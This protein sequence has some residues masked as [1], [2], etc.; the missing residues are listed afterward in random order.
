VK[1]QGIRIMDVKLTG[2]MSQKHVSIQVCPV[3]TSGVIPASTT[4]SSSYVFSPVV[5]VR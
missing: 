4:G 3:M 2:S 5:L 1:W